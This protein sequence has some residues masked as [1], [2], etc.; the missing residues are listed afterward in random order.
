MPALFFPFGEPWSVFEA[1]LLAQP[2]DV[3]V[4]KTWDES[5]D[6]DRRRWVQRFPH[7]RF[8]YRYTVETKNGTVATFAI[9]PGECPRCGQPMVVGPSVSFT[10]WALGTGLQQRRKG[11]PARCTV[12]AK[13]DE[14]DASRRTSARYRENNPKAPIE[15]RDCLACGVSFTPKRS[16]ARCC[17]GKCRAKLSR[18]EAKGVA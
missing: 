3:A 6:W 15:P 8:A 18:Q 11:Y 9:C 12:C 4:I 10:S 5:S 7:P 14:R 1:F 16:D 17:S 13:K 2:A